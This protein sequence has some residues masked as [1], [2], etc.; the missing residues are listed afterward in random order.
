MGHAHVFFA[1]I[2]TTAA[3]TIVR[4]DDGLPLPTAAPRVAGTFET[5]RVRVVKGDFEN[6]LALVRR[7]VPYHEGGGRDRVDGHLDHHHRRASRR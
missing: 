1:L 2:V 3:P 6:D 5:I 4:A 7:H